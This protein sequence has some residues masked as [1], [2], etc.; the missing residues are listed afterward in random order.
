M[1]GFEGLP[2]QVLPKRLIGVSATLSNGPPSIIYKP[3]R[4][5]LTLK[6]LYHEGALSEDCESLRPFA[7]S[8]S[9][10][11]ISRSSF[12]GASGSISRTSSPSNRSSISPKALTLG[13]STY[14][15]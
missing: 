15:D 4:I 9:D 7:G 8:L 6:A 2:L 1:R 10:I 12:L 13:S 3:S 5:F 14:S 11:S